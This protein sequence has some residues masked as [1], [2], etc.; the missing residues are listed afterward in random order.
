MELRSLDELAW[1][2]AVPFHFCVWKGFCWI[3]LLAVSDLKFLLPFCKGSICFS[4][5]VS[6]RISAYTK[7][8]IFDASCQ[9]CFSKIPFVLGPDF[10]K[11]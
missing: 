9:R 1:G 2:N 5:H 8:N 7:T 6:K 10:N 11:I 3:T 4:I